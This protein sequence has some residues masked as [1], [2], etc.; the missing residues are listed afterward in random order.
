MARTP[1]KPQRSI[2]SF[3][4][5]GEKEVA[6]EGEVAAEETRKDQVEAKPSVG[7][8]SEGDGNAKMLSMQVVEDLVEDVVVPEEDGMER[9][10]RKVSRADDWR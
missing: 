9:T 3:F 5:P 10:S 6:A 4:R 8:E 1:T 7:S 2:A